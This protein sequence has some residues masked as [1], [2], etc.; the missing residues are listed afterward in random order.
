MAHALRVFSGSDGTFQELA[1]QSGETFAALAERAAGLAQPQTTPCSV[2]CA[3]RLVVGPPPFAGCPTWAAAGEANAAAF[4]SAVFGE[5]APPP[6]LVLGPHDDVRKAAEQVIAAVA[7]E[8]AALATGWATLRLPKEPPLQYSAELPGPLLL[9]EHECRRHGAVPCKGGAIKSVTC[10]FA[11]LEDLQAFVASME[12]T[13]LSIVAQHAR[14]AASPQRRGGGGGNVAE[15]NSALRTCIN[16]LWLHQFRADWPDSADWGALGTASC[17]PMASWSLA[18][19]VH[20]AC[21]ALAVARLLA[22]ALRRP[23]SQAEEALSTGRVQSAWRQ[24]RAQGVYASRLAALAEA[25]ALDGGEALTEERAGAGHFSARTR[26]C[27]RL[28]IRW[29]GSQLPPMPLTFGPII[30]DDVG[31]LGCGALAVKVHHSTSAGALCAAL[32]ARSRSEEQA[33]LRLALHGR[34]LPT[35]G[36]LWRAGVE[37]L[38]EVEVLTCAAPDAPQA[39]AAPG[40]PEGVQPAVAAPA[41]RPLQFGSRATMLKVIPMVGPST[42][43]ALRG[44]CRTQAAADFVW[45][46]V[47]QLYFAEELEG[48]P[49]WFPLVRAAF[50][51]LPR[52]LA[53]SRRLHATQARAHLGQDDPVPLDEMDDLSRAVI[54]YA[55]ESGMSRF[56]LFRVGGAA[57]PA[58]HAA[59][60]LL[61]LL[62]PQGCAFDHDSLVRVGVQ[63]EGEEASDAAPDFGHGVWWLRMRLPMLLHCLREGTLDALVAALLPEA[64]R[65]PVW[66][67]YL[68]ASPDVEGDF[69][70][71]VFVH[72]LKPEPVQV[73][74]AMLLQFVTYNVG[75]GWEN[76]HD[77]ALARSQRLRLRHMEEYSLTEHP[78]ADRYDAQDLQGMYEELFF[79]TVLAGGSSLDVL[80]A[81]RFDPYKAPL[82]TGFAPRYFHASGLMVTEQAC[83]TIFNRTTGRLVVVV[84]L[85]EMQW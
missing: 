70:P 9:R 39:A 6:L 27:L 37:D 3:G 26:C 35:D 50:E 40:P 68:G 1:L 66:R 46:E 11:T 71:F 32:R 83:T 29:P 24:L 2:L 62:F 42:L 76:N 13:R 8:L 49:P 16:F 77:F 38:D 53:A 74:D 17:A 10:W 30:L 51:R 47:A 20:V 56:S 60:L 25:L 52:Q 78:L 81:F 5:T 18:V 14:G 72:R 28:R 22:A 41:G 15:A 55:R 69:R 54:Q 82:F 65:G 75:M 67:R 84:N 57:A 21:A 19:S 12:E 85:E 23:G 59:A 45:R 61:T 58:T 44:C 79:E 31:R 64:V 33:P 73:D 4:F 63:P 7:Q 48:G 43:L 34:L 36:P 80:E